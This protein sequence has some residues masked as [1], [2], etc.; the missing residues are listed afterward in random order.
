[1]SKPSHLYYFMLRSGVK[2]AIFVGGRLKPGSKPSTVI[3]TRPSGEHVLEVQRINVRPLSQQLAVE[4]IKQQ[5]QSE[6]SKP[7]Q[8]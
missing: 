1:M 8:A 3:L 6:Q 4:I 2:E 5:I 7:E